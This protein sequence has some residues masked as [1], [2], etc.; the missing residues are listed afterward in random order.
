MERFLYIQ[1]YKNKVK[2]ASREKDMTVRSRL[3]MEA[4]ILHRL[5]RTVDYMGGMIE[6]FRLKNGVIVVRQEIYRTEKSHWYVVQD[7]GTMMIAN[8]PNTLE[9]AYVRIFSMG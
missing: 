6:M 7:D 4:A 5:I 8:E 1:E 9:K 3:T 2:S